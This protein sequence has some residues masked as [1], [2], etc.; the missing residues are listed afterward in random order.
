MLEEALAE[1]EGTLLVI[2]H[3]RYFLDQVCTR[4]VHVDSGRVDQQAGNYCAN[5]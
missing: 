5:W 2:S 3:D 4:I 1:Y